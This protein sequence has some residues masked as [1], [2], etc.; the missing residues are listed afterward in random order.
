MRRPWNLC[1][2]PVHSLVTQGI[3]GQTNM[4]VCTYVSAISMEPKIYAVAVYHGTKSLENLMKTESAV[5]Q[6]LHKEQFSLVNTLGKKS[7]FRYNKMAYLQKKN[8]LEEWQ[9]RPVLKDVCARL[10]LRKMSYQT[11]GDH[12]LFLFSVE[13]YQVL[14]DNYLTIN[15]LREKK[16][17]YG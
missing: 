16:I 1:D 5:L 12:D 4:N 7:G 8:L 11:T 10:L 3:D 15:H 14:S 13:K 6:I 9:E 17:I 2:L